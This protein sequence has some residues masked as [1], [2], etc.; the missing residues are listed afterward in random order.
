MGLDFRVHCAIGLG[1]KKLVWVTF[2]NYVDTILSFLTTY[3]PLHFSTLN[4]DDNRHF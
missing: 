4:V 1:L 2:N 3:L